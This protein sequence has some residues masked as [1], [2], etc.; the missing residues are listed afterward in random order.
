MLTRRHGERQVLHQHALRAIR[1]GRSYGDFIEHD[2]RA[3]GV[4][5]ACRSQ[6]SLVFARFLARE[7]QRFEQLRKPVRVSG[8][9][10]EIFAEKQHFGERAAASKH[11]LLGGSEG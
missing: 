1:L 4:V 11:E 10:V 3:F 7:I 9:F 8:E 5:S 2:R 6:F